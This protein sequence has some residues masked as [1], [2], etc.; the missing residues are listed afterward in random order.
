MAMTVQTRWLGIDVSKK[1]L[2]ICLEDPHRPLTLPNEPRAIARWLK[3]L[4]P[5]PVAI[6]VEATNT[7]HLALCL[8]AHQA[9][10]TVYLVD[11]YRLSRYRDSMGV[12]A[13]TDTT[14]AQL[15]R[16]YLMREH[17]S[18]RPWSPPP[19][20]YTTLLQLLTRRATLVKARGAL[21]QSLADIPE[22]KRSTNACLRQ[23]ARLDA[24]IQTRILTALRHADWLNDAQRLQA[25]EGIGPLTS[26]ALTMAFHRAPFATSDAFIAYLGLDVRVRDSG[27]L[28]GRRRLSK[29]GHPELRR[30]LYLAAMA[31]SHTLTWR[32]FY[33]RY[34][35]RGLKRTQALVI[36]ARK[37]ARIAFALL[38]TQSVYQPELRN[39]CLET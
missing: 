39:L 37:L 12:R 19:K 18:L 28:K 36:L 27:Q 29:K 17:D 24:L 16:R 10:H 23:L 30:L 11:G 9:G 13:K 38:R 20:A 14:D 34:L 6:A 8:K 31:A 5:G 1:T 22:L 4:P 2:D 7:F 35:N 32:E 3:T 15:L 25:I 21:Q 33:Q 26:A